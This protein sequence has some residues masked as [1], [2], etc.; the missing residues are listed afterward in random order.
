[1]NRMLVEPLSED[2]SKLSQY[3]QEMRQSAR[4]GN[5]L[6]Q[7]S[8][9]GFYS[10]HDGPSSSQ[11]LIYLDGNA[12]MQMDRV[13]VAPLS[14]NDAQAMI[15]GAYSG[16]A[17]EVGA[18]IRNVESIVFADR[19]TMRAFRKLAGN[20]TQPLSASNTYFGPVTAFDTL[21]GLKFC[22]SQKVLTDI[23]N[24]RW[25]LPEGKDKNSIDSWLGAPS[26][27]GSTLPAK[28]R[29]LEESVRFDMQYVPWTPVK[30][31]DGLLKLERSICVSSAYTGVSSGFSRLRDMETHGGKTTH[32][33]RTSPRVQHELSL[34][35]ELT[36]ADFLVSHSAARQYSLLATG[37]TKL[38]ADKLVDCLSSSGIILGNRHK[39][40]RVSISN[41]S[42]ELSMG[43]RLKDDVPRGSQVYLAETPFPGRFVKIENKRWIGVEPYTGPKNRT[44]PLDVLI[45]GGQ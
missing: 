44:V 27:K 8:P 15:I 21:S 19:N 3:R 6:I 1:M 28:L 33:S 35:G 31:F 45:A 17:P 34:N 26:V 30:T 22:E 39:V 29:S 11:P 37:S 2:M 23:L 14:R 40:G 13:S 9:A 5:A 18:S 16:V 43:G 24:H 25:W 32:L 20:N 42:P 10:T 36:R 38:V 7:R 12:V 4:E 41:G